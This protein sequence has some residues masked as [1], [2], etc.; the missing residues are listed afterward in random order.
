MLV[1]IFGAAGSP[2]EIMNFVVPFSNDAKKSFIE[3]AIKS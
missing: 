3:V 2:G 1:H